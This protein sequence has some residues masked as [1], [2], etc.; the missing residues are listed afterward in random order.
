MLALTRRHLGA[1]AALFTAIGQPVVI[2][3]RAGGGGSTG[4]DAVAKSTPD[5]YTIGITGPG[6]LVAA[7]FMTKVP[8]DATKDLAPIA[9]VA[10][11]NGVIVVAASSPYKTLNDLVGAAFT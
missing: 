5:G 10:R 11:V 1:C 6:A 9:R 3:N 4:V 7:P 2:E 8:Y